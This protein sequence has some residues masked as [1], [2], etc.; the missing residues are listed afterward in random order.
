MGQPQSL[1]ATQSSANF[2]HSSRRSFTLSAGLRP[3]ITAMK[4]SRFTRIGIV[5]LGLIL[6]ASLVVSLVTQGPTTRAPEAR[7]GHCPDCGRRLSPAAITAGQCPFCQ[8]TKGPD[9][10]KLDRTTARRGWLFPAI[11]G[12]AIVVLAI[13]YSV[14]WF[15][16][17]RA[18]AK[19]E[20]Q[21][22][23]NCRKC[24]RRL[25]Y[26]ERQAG[27]PAQCPLCRSFLVFPR[28]ERAP[29]RWQA[30]IRRIRRRQADAGPA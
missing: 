20:T 11:T 16:T 29:S 22:R 2:S 7:E 13:L 9:A 10:G 23:V 26:R 18:T 8:L 3:T 17:R 19:E 4:A 25:R 21:Y 14:L 24:G 27:K 12:G 6:T 15:R 30:L 5:V 1:T 28:I